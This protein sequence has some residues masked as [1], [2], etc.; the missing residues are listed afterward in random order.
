MLVKEF[1]KDNCISSLTPK[2]TNNMGMQVTKV[3]GKD[4]VD[5]L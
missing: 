2:I 1:R 4:F 5:H 3:V